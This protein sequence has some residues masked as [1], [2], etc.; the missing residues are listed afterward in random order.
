[1]ISSLIVIKVND[2]VGCV[3]REHRLKCMNR[4]IQL[5]PRNDL[6]ILLRI[7]AET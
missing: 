3:H 1:M 6:W 7:P 5:V 4:G 2:E